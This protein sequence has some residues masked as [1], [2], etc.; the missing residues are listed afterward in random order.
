MNRL[1]VVLALLALLAFGVA[2]LAS[3]AQQPKWQHEMDQARRIAEDGNEH[4]IVLTFPSPDK[5]RSGVYVFYNNPR[6]F[7]YT[8][9]VPGEWVGSPR[10]RAYRSKDGR[11]F[12]GVRFL[13]P[14]TLAGEDG[15]TLVERAGSYITRLYKREYGRALVGI[16]FVPFASLR[17]ETWQWR[18]APIT[19]TV[20]R[21]DFPAKLIVDLSPDAIAQVT[22]VGTTDDQQLQLARQIVESL[23][24]SKDPECYFSVLESMYKAMYDVQQ[25]SGIQGSKR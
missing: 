16:E 19:N 15:A 3:K 12:A 9:M 11:A 2:P 14:S 23:R 7:C 25:G 4:S 13:L 10:E 22:V 6:P 24:T 18:A 8:Y 20:P 5:G 1:H 17:P 21:V